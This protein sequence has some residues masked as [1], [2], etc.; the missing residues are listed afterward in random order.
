MDITE[1]LNNQNNLP[2]FER[3]GYQPCFRT[4]SATSALMPYKA[5][6]DFRDSCFRIDKDNEM[7]VFFHL[8]YIKNETVY[9]ARLGEIS[10]RRRT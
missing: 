10:E 9:E 6:S 3:E 4:V 2:L 7:I 8:G 1:S 5:E